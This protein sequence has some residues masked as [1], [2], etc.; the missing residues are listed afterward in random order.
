MAGGSGRTRS[1]FRGRRHSL[2]LRVPLPFSTSK[3]A[4]KRTGYGLFVP[5]TPLPVSARGQRVLVI[6]DDASIRFLC[7]VNLELEGWIV[8]EAATIDAA[9]ELLRR[10]G[11]SV[12]L[13]DV[14][15][16]AQ[17]GL[18]FLDEIRTAEPGVSVAL[19]TGSDLGA[20]RAG[21][22]ADAVVPKPFAPEQLTETVR[23]LA[24]RAGSQ[25]G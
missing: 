13:L 20:G 5:Y 22:G 14:H 25:A 3:R 7:R 10:G 9:R 4:R 17:S 12:V 16:G 21:S 15:V 2:G 23:A 1:T 24:A 11:V 8:D 19:L 18:A 6:D